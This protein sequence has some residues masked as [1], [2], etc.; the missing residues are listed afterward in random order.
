QDFIFKHT[1]KEDSKIVK[2]YEEK[3]KK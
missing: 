3:F 2:Y 1:A